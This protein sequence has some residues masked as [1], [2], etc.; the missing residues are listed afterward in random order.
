MTTEIG[1]SA[2]GR[3]GLP[4]VDRLL[5]EAS[6]QLLV[7][8]YSR[9][10]VV[11]EV[12][13]MLTEVRGEL[14]G[15]NPPAPLSALIARLGER[16]RAHEPSLRRVINA[17]GV[18]I[19]TNLGRAPLSSDAIA[20]MSSVAGGYSNLE[21]DL[22]A[23]ERGSRH[24]HLDRILRAVTGA[25]AAIAVNN[26]AAALF[27]TL[28]TLA[29]GREVIVS[30]G[31][32]VEIGGGFRI[33]DVMSQSGC[34]LVEV[35]TTNRTYLRDYAD[36]ITS[37]TALLLRVH[38]SNFRVVGFTTAVEAAELA[39]L[40][41]Q[42]GIPVLDDIGSGALL[43][44][45]PCGL[46]HEPTVGESVADGVD[47]VCCSGDKL[48]GGP[49]AGIIAGRADIVDRIRRHP[50]ARAVRIDKATLAALV[51]TLRH[52]QR[53]EALDRVPIWQMIAAPAHELETR[54]RSWSDQL[55]VHGTESAVV[56]T[57][58]TIGG[59]SL[60]GETLPTRALALSVPSPNAFATRLR[61]TEPAV[62]ARIEHDAV[63]FDPRTVLPDQD[64][65]LLEAILAATRE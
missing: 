34:R 44:T 55:R 17:T 40:G 64:Q 31:Q 51:A 36:A 53:G 4:G 7:A 16:L 14:V 6:V 46:A 59:G 28:A 1:R 33:P 56:A 54:A 48:L 65:P 49:Q 62:I 22:D 2:S 50:I 29:A 21:L 26:N 47:V 42:H 60:P 61:R 41:R 63:L 13:A 23:G 45:T 12:R 43:D 19:H 11:D 8:E 30:R 3:R 57:E 32:A 52:Y 38:T 27:L 15:D 37:E 20:A 25:E 39:A 24:S 9:S 18:I 35:G 58:S 10:V 5:Q